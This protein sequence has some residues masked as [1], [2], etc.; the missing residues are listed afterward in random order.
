VTI[1]DIQALPSMPFSDYAR[2][3]NLRAIYF[4][5][6]ESAE[7]LYIGRTDSLAM[8]WRQHHLR[9]R[10]RQMKNISIAWLEID[11]ESARPTE[12][13][14]INQFRPPLNGRID[15]GRASSVKAVVMFRARPDIEEDM[16]LAR[17]LRLAAHLSGISMTE[18]MKQGIETRLNE[19]A[20]KYPELA[21]AA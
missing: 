16:D 6:S 15:S 14:L 13:L 7:I 11:A 10:L 20:N 17:R 2:L 12:I 5:L 19:L 18:I 4:V 8:R 21:R 9:A 1:S 3:P